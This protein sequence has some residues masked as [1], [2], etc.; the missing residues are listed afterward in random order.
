MRCCSAALRET[1][2]QKRK[3]VERDVVGRVIVYW[4][5]VNETV[6]W[7]KVTEAENRLRAARPSHASELE[8]V[9]AQCSE[10]H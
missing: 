10:G 4:F 7:V 8:H 1:F 5:G 6:C 3:L 9:H 2:R